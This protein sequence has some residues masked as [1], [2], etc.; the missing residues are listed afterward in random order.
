MQ[1]SRI[2]IC[3]LLTEGKGSGKMYRIK[4]VLFAVL[5]AALLV[6]PCGAAEADKSA[7]QKY[8]A[9]TFDDGPTAGVTEQLL[10]GLQARGARATFFLCGYRAMEFPDTVARI[11][12][13][14]HEIGVHGWS[15]MCL[16]EAQAEEILQELERTSA[17][18]EAQ[19]GIRPKLFRPPGG[20]TS[21]VL[22]ETAEE[23]E[24]SVILWGVDP[25]DWCCEDADTVV[26][27]ILKNAHD[28]DIVLMH[29]LTK[30]SVFAALTLID[31]LQSEGYQF[32]TVSELAAARGKELSFGK[33]Y[34]HFPPREH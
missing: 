33:A 10:S 15:H 24:F 21:K 19:T 12:A 25:E 2:Q 11:A 20:L 17:L 26:R 23:C 22:L 8:I 4:R 14:G 27:R 34:W 16:H 30:S 28:G 18:L 1:V 5:C 32:C 29:D 3:S 13:D 6:Q 9:I 31:T 7:A